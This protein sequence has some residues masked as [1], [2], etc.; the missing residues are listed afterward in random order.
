MT[1]LGQRFPDIVMDDCKLTL[2]R[3]RPNVV[4]NGWYTLV[5]QPVANEQIDVG[6]TMAPNVGPTLLRTLGQRT[7]NG[8]MLS[9]KTMKRKITTPT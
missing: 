5:G 8:R 6:A 1:E 2:V 3:R 4:T 7:A 9:G